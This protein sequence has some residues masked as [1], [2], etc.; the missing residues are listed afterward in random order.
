MVIRTV[1]YYVTAYFN[2][3]I[4]KKSKATA[5]EKKKL[6]KLYE[7]NLTPRLTI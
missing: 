2:L 3:S 5:K 6:S 1:I 7:D 4:R